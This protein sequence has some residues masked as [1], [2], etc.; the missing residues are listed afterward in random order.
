MADDELLEILNRKE[1]SASHYVHGNLATEREMALREYYRLPYGNEDDGWSQIVASDIQDVVEWTLPAILK[2]FTSTDKAVQFE[3]AT[4]ADVE[5]AEQATDAVN[6]VFHKQ[7]NGF[8]VLYTAVKDM[9]TVRNC[10]VMWRKETQETVSSVP[11]KNASEE[12][13]AMLLQEEDAEIQEANPAPVIDPQ[14]GQPEI[15]L[16][17]GQPVMGYSGRLKKTEQKT[18]VKVEAFSPED[19]LVERDWTSPLLQ[20]CPYVARLMHVT[21]SDLQMMGFDVT[22]EDLRGSDVSDFS[23]DAQFRLNKVNQTDVQSGTLG[24]DRDQS[25]DDSMAEGWLRIEYILADADGD[26]IAERLCVHRLQNKIL[27]RE[28]CSHVPIATSSPILNTHRWDGMSM[29][30]AVSDLQKLHTDLL[31]QTLDN[32]KLT[33]N[34]RKNVLTDAN[35]SPLAN[36][37]DLLDSRIGGIVRVR[38]PNAVTDNIVPFTAG[39]SMPMLEYVQGMRENRTGVS[40][41]S[42]GLNPDSLNNTA[43][44]RQIDQS[45]AMQRI[46][47]IA[48][49]VAETLMKPIFMGILK[50]LTDG[51]M[52]KLCFRLRDKFVEYDPNTWR[53]QYDMTVNVGLGTGDKAQQAAQLMAIWQMQT[54]GLQFG[55][56]TPKHLYATAAK[57]IENAGFKDVQ[58][59]VQ[60]PST[61]PPQPQQPPLPLQ[62]EQMKQQGDAQKFQAET[63]AD[64]QK[65]QAET[66]MTRE[67]EQ[68]KA[69]LKMKEIQANLELQAANDQRDSEREM[70]KAQYDAQLAQ[71]QLEFDK[72]KTEFDAQTKVYIEE[73]KLRG[74][75]PSDVIQHKDDMLQVLQGLQ[76]V[77]AQMSAPKQIIRDA[78]GKALGIQHVQG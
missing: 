68:I 51:G 76:A 13:L 54:A 38:D 52:E 75:P 69:E 77:V 65:F 4:A 2:V 3:P 58:N 42:M 71:Q 39:S 8:L 55:I 72:W 7:N 16:M 56:T 67:V 46:E 49:I 12:M 15:D 36:L 43:T 66:Q 9:L 35:W 31:R 70:L 30:D 33:N 25:E 22:A 21:L 11:F 59:F 32:L 78:N 53:D 20:E 63:Q 14:T 27:K 24:H 6:Y 45:A 48:R 19:L 26:G 62:I 74:A 73:M 29:A 57:Q 64:I 37:D 28:V 17:T 44:G 41:T 10:A 61:L 40:R 34:P 18:I 47:L 23:A 1:D 60:D 50:V 5:S